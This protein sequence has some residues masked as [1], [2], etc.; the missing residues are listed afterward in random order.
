MTQVLVTGATGFVGHHLVRHLVTQPDLQ[1]AC[2]VRAGSR[3]DELTRLAVR[4][5]EGDLTDP[6]S[7][8]GACDGVDT[9]YHCACAVQDTFAQSTNSDADFHAVNADGTLVLARE[10]LRA[11]VR[12]MV[13]VSSTA[14]M[15][16]PEGTRIDE[17]SPCSPTTP[18][19]RSKRAAELGLLQLHSE[20]GLP[21]VI[22]R[23]CLV[24]GTGKRNSELLRLFKLVRWGAFPFFGGSAPQRKP[25]V[26]VSDLV[27]AME[28][29]AGRGT[30]GSIF[31]VTSGAAY[32]LERIVAVVARLLGVRRS[33]FSIP[34]D[35]AYLAAMLLEGLGRVVGFSPPLT[36]ARLRLLTSDRELVIDRARHQL[37]YDPQ[38]T[39]L[40]P[41]LREVHEE[42][43]REGQL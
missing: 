33:H 24:V 13:H 29:A 15:G 19:G 41:L 38:R 27:A 36:R 23:P 31:L 8:H 42:F 2:L 40:E 9:V 10:A 20:E 21:V 22:V 25:L 6:A 3:R 14:A 26:H 5:V 39:D 32:P 11:G 12:R 37:G 34:V 30:P 16:A 17:D 4:V 28:L 43:V 7:L 35:L 1:V 18:Y